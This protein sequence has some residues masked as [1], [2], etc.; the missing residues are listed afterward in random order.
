MPKINTFYKIIIAISLLAT[1]CTIIY[2]LSSDDLFAGF[3]WAYLAALYI[4]LAF[5]A[6]AYGVV[7]LSRKSKSSSAKANKIRSILR[8]VMGGGLVLFWVTTA[9]YAFYWY[10]NSGSFGF[11]FFG[12]VTAIF[13]SPVIMLIFGANKKTLLISLCCSVVALIVVFMLYPNTVPKEPIEVLE[14]FL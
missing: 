13:L 14:K 1:L 12:I 7:Q 2:D 4:I 6:L 5:I 3:A 9:Y 8:I 10:F 11:A